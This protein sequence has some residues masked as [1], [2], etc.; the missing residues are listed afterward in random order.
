MI[1]ETIICTYAF[2]MLWFPEKQKQK[3]DSKEIVVFILGE[4]QFSS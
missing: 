4:R 3:N 2:F 1:S